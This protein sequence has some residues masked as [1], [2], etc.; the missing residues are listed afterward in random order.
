MLRWLRG[1]RAAPEIP[2]DQWQAV[3]AAYP[4]LCERPAEELQ[5]LRE[6]SAV[7]LLLTV[8]AAMLL[9]SG[10]MADIRVAFPALSS[11]MNWLEALD[12]PFDMDDEPMRRPSGILPDHAEDPAADWAPRLP[13]W[14]RAQVPAGTPRRFQ[15]GPLHR[16]RQP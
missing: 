7:L 5:R 12:T 11:V 3:L 2:D 6:L 9:T 1:L 16:V 4:F 10:Q 15:N 8:L 13:G 14:P